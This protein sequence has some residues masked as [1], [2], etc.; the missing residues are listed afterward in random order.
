[1]LVMTQQNCL[2]RGGSYFVVLYF[3]YFYLYNLDEPTCSVCQ[4]KFISVFGFD[5]ILFDRN[6][7][8]FVIQHSN[9]TKSEHFLF[10]NSRDL[11][12]KVDWAKDGSASSANM[13]NEL[14][15]DV[16][17]ELVMTSVSFDICGDEMLSVFPRLLRLNVV[18]ADVGLMRWM[19]RRRHVFFA[20]LARWNRVL[21]N[22]GIQTKTIK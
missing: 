13:K 2:A 19:D 14:K 8:F 16:A 3:E 22:V 12:K 20:C 7:P 4:R 9:Q 18:Y 6:V 1:M 11:K 21:F 10:N 15:G 5:A 17:C